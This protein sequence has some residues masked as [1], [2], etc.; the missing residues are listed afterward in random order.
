MLPS[1]SSEYP[2][3]HAISS[4]YVLGASAKTS[5]RFSVSVFLPVL[6]VLPVLPLPSVL[7]GYPLLF[8]LPPA[9]VGAGS[10]ET[11]LKGT[12]LSGGPKSTRTTDLPVISGVL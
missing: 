12:K 4:V 10:Y 6:L 9:G 11:A 3:H 2:V 8:V 7:F 5:S 1:G